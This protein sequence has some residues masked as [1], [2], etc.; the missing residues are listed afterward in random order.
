MIELLLLKLQI[1]VTL[2]MAYLCITIFFLTHVIGKFHCSLT[3]N[4][5][6]QLGS[7]L[8]CEQRS[9]VRPLHVLIWVS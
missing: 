7:P 2:A 4:A 8:V 1:I 5:P 3:P 9:I 6:A